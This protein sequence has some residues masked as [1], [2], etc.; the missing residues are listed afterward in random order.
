MLPELLQKTSLFQLLFKIDESLLNQ[1][2]SIACRH[3]GGPLY[4]SNYMRKPRGGAENTPEEYNIR[5]SLCC[6]CEHCRKRTLPPSCRFMGRRVYWAAAILVVMALRQNRENNHSTGKLIEL[7]KISRN[8]L[9]SWFKYFKENFPESAQWHR[10]RGRVSPV[11]ENDMVP[12]ALLW[13]FIRT[14]QTA[15]EALIQCLRFMEWGG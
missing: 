2:Q 9:R 10:I 15:E 7:F 6:G 5:F 13:L 1:H 8:T 14:K 12:G 4:Q 11:I 3:C